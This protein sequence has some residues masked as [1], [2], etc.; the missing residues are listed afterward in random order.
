MLQG[1][2]IIDQHVDHFIEVI[3]NRK[4]EKF[5]NLKEELNNRIKY[6]SFIRL[7]P[8]RKKYCVNK[9]YNNLT[10][11]DKGKSIWV[12]VD[13]TKTKHSMIMRITKNNDGTFNIQFANTGQG[14]LSHE[15]FHP[16]IIHP[17]T[18][19]HLFQIVAVIKGVANDKLN[20]QF[21]YDLFSKVDTKPV[22]D[23]E[24]NDK[25]ENEVN[26]SSSVINSIYKV[27]E[28]LGNPSVIN[29]DEDPRYWSTTQIGGSC[30]AGCVWALIKVILPQDDIIY[31]CAMDLNIFFART[32]P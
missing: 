32:P 2:G 9:I 23:E 30:S 29:W 6:G 13:S 22:N 24:F 20:K 3:E 19:K 25:N 16:S 10:R 1:G 26:D 17:N 18:K 11:L 5:K 7:L 14:L 8:M 12:D 28:K 21:F 31:I 15:N 4:E 27:L